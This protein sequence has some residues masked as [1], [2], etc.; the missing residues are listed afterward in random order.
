MVTRLKGLLFGGV[1]LAKKK[2]VM[3]LDSIC[4]KNFHNLTV[5]RVKMSLFLELI[6][7][8]LCILITREK[9]S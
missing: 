9:I 8:N 3:V 2:L 6:S 4:I 7:A 5:A 1:K